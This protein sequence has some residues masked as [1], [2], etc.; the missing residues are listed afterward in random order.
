M[1]KQVKN[2]D[3][4][5]VKTTKER[6]R[7]KTPKYFKEI[8]KWA[9]YVAGICTTA[10]GLQAMEWIDLPTTVWR[11]ISYVLLAATVIAAGCLL[12]TSDNDLSSK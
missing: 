11:V 8:R 10:L 3:M 12:P 2:N 6:L 5:F 9:L 4:N 1:Q 7:S